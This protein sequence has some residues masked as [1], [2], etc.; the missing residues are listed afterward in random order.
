MEKVFM[1][2]IKKLLNI[3]SN[4]I[5]YKR[6]SLCNK[7]EHYKFFQCKICKC[8][9]PLKARI[10]QTNCPINKWSNPYNSWGS[11]A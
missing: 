11:N 3:F 1:K 4:K 2:F 8:I 6:I 9:M 7:C 10:V 5:Y